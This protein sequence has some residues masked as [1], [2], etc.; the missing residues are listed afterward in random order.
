[1][2]LAYLTLS[3]LSFAYGLHA[4]RS[5]RRI[6]EWPRVKANVVRWNE[7]GPYGKRFS[8]TKTQE[9]I[10][11]TEDGTERTMRLIPNPEN[12]YYAELVY[13]WE[14]RPHVAD[15]AFNRPVIDSFELLINPSD[16]SDYLPHAPS[17]NFPH[18]LGALSLIFLYMAL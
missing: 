7:A 18:F 17:L 15:L 5:A 14:G 8:R 4:A 1:M 3:G 16:P 9:V 12:V 2:D 6:A 11:I 13:I 10:V